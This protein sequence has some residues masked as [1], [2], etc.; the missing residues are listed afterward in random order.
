MIGP[1]LCRRYVKAYAER[2]PSLDTAE[3]IG[4]LV[5]DPVLEGVTIQLAD[6]QVQN[7]FISNGVAAVPE[8]ASLLLLTG[9]LFARARPKTCRRK[10]GMD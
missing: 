1:A 9:G 6:G 4:R 5:G 7:G 2:S 8:P 10:T 3:V